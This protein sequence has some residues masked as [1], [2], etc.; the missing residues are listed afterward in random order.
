M[1]K[2]QYCVLITGQQLPLIMGPREH[3]EESIQAV[4]FP[5]CPSLFFL[6]F[7]ERGGGDRERKKRFRERKMWAD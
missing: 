3:R 1:Q 6:V 5:Y 2:I 4:E 7:G